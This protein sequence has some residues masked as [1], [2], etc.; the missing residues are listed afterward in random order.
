M[1]HYQTLLDLK[2]STTKANHMISRFHSSSANGGGWFIWQ[3]GNNSTITEIPGIIVKPIGLTDGYWV[4]QEYLQGIPYTPEM[5]GASSFQGTMSAQGWTQADATLVY[6]G[7]SVTVTADTADATAIQAMFNA[8]FAVSNSINSDI[9]T[10][11]FSGRDY[12]LNKACTMPRFPGTMPSN[13]PGRMVRFVLN[14]NGARIRPLTTQNF[15]LFQSEISSAAD[16]EQGQADRNLTI[17]DFT[18]DGIGATGAGVSYC[19]KLYGGTSNLIE[20]CHFKGCDY[21]LWLGFVIN[22]IIERCFAQHNKTCGYYIGYSNGVNDSQSNQTTVSNCKVTPPTGSTI[23]RGYIVENCNN[24][25]MNG[26]IFEGPFKYGIEIKYSGSTAN[27]FKV[28]NVHWEAKAGST[29]LYNE[30]LH[31]I[32]IDYFESG[33]PNTVIVESNPSVDV[34][35]YISNIS[36]VQVGQKY[37]HRGN[38]DATSFWFFNNVS[39]NNNTIKDPINWVTTSGYSVPNFTPVQY[40][41]GDTTTR[42]QRTQVLANGT[43]PGGGAEQA[44]VWEG[45]FGKLKQANV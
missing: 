19:L 31:H 12:F 7:L 16:N 2:R 24:V 3:K 5:F 28:S 6:P 10:C 30:R 44:R 26:V 33:A 41:N 43:L 39:A 32:Y 22:N 14:G 13:S 20:G 4:R 40:V 21:G 38:P 45:Y 1:A 8:M 29:F 25:E 9:K 15:A 37:A 34:H 11:N 27:A 36:Y 17:R 42:V 35:Y 18:F 23:A